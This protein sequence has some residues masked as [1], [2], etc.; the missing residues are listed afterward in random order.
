M[1]IV[2]S[3]IETKNLDYNDEVQAKEIILR[4]KKEYLHNNIDNLKD[5]SFWT[6]AGNPNFDGTCSPNSLKKFDGDH[7]ILAYA[8]AR[9]IYQDFDFSSFVLGTDLTG[10]TINTFR[11]LF[12]NRFYFKDNDNGETLIEKRFCFS[13]EEK[14][15]R[16]DFFYKYQTVGNFSLLPCEILLCNLTKNPRL[17]NQSINTFRGTVSNWKDYFDVFLGKL[18]KC[19]NS[20]NLI[21]KD[22]IFLRELLLKGNNKKFFF[23][24]CEGSSTKFKS[25]FLLDDYSEKLF[26]HPANYYFGA[27]RYKGKLDLYKKFAFTYIDIANELIDRRSL[28]IIKRL[29][30]VL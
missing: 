8:I 10:D 30:K 27:F 11:T 24:F 13:E 19:L 28:E 25:I 20:T 14:Q 5:F 26:P 12:G 29:K 6:I 23:D 1:G 18:D 3:D 21:N 17:Q 22:E 15:K 4:F 7:T 9:L 16:N 2:L